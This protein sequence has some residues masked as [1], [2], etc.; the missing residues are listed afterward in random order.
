M[1]LGYIKDEN[2]KLVRKWVNEGEEG[3]DPEVLY[4]VTSQ[5]GDY[6]WT[7][8][9]HM[10]EAKDVLLERMIDTIRNLAKLDEFWSVKREADFRHDAQDHPSLVMQPSLS[11]EDFVPQEAKDG[12]CTVAWKIELPQF[13]GYYEWNEAEKIRKQLDECC[14]HL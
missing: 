1:R 3:K 11:V 14:A 10:D 7:D 12:K 2:G 6:I 4:Q 8:D 5:F 13:G 9:E